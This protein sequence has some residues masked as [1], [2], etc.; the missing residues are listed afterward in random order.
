MSWFASVLVVVLKLFSWNDY[1]QIFFKHEFI[2]HFKYLL[3]FSDQHW[4]LASALLNCILE[5]SSLFWWSHWFSLVCSSVCNITRQQS[6]ITFDQL[7]SVTPDLCVYTLQLMLFNG[8]NK[9][10]IS[11]TNI[12]TVFMNKA[13]EMSDEGPT[14]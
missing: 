3:L 4:H 2:L 12:S 1:N 11:Y 14:L 13:A 9:T 10:R 5:R 7:C 6:N 8:K